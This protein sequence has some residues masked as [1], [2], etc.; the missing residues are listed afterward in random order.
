MV[1]LTQLQYVVAVDKERHF[2]R[3]AKACH[4]AQP[5][6]S[7]QIR[8]MEE[9]LDVV[10]FD[11]S[12]N[13]IVPTVVG[14]EIIK[15]A[16]IILQE[17]R[18]LEPLAQ[19]ASSH[20]RGK[21]HLAV[22][23]TLAPYLIPFFIGSFS[24]QYPKVQLKISENQTDDII[25]LLEEDEIDAGLLVTP[26]RDESIVERHLFLEPFY[27]YVSKQ[28]PLSSKK[29]LSEG[30][31]DDKSLWILEEGHCFRDQVLKVCS[32]D[33]KNR[34]LGNV[35]FSSGN[36]ETLKNLVRKNSGY[37]LLPE[38]ALSDMNANEKKQ[39]IRNFRKPVPTRE[40]SL[41]HSRSFLKEPILN[42]LE[43][44]IIA[45]LPNNIHSHKRKDLVVVD[46]K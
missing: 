39:F 3:A 33:S 40:V 25:K 31:L 1:T 46:F 30:D 4:V 13:P 42:A 14:L 9:E 29:S 2:G 10:I 45:R 19:R 35:E 8:K 36:L 28:H 12:K 37:T 5:S 6:L 21:F 44:T 27:A 20:P 17:H 38:L 16:E 15:Q 7:M 22:I 18:K 34:A 11:R 41:V 43:E 24:K 26:L 23:P 32:F